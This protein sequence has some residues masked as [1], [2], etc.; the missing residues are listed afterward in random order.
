M[1]AVLL[2]DVHIDLEYKEGTLVDCGDYLCCREENGYPEPGQEGAGEWGA[3]PCDPP[4]KTF[5]NM[6][7]HIATEI[8]PDVVFWTG[9]NSPH[10]I[11]SLTNEDVTNYTIEVT[12]MIKDKLDGAG[13][14]VIPTQ[15]NHDTWPIDIQSFDEPNSNYPINHFKQYWADW[16]D[17]QALEK[18]GEYGYYS[19]DLKL[20]NGKAVPKGSKIIAVNTLACD[21]NNFILMNERNDPGHQLEWLEAE[22]LQIETDGGIAILIGHHAPSSCLHQWGTRFRALMERF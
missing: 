5:N 8:R 3:F 20:K 19:M 14:T 11:W 13:I 7:D 9:D 10:N 15:G 21:N 22:L 17:E 6:L 1:K 16:L 4:V 12:Q 2:T 18:F